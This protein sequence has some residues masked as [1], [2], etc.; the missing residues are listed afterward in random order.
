MPICNKWKSLKSQLRHATLS[1][2]TWFMFIRDQLKQFHK[3]EHTENFSHSWMCRYVI[4]GARRATG[5]QKKGICGVRP[6]SSGWISSK[7]E[8]RTNSK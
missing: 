6:T 1:Q 5:G 2:K 4:F 3:Y 8:K 7:N